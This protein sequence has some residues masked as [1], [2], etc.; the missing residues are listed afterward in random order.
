MKKTIKIEFKDQTTKTFEV[1][2]LATEATNIILRNHLECN[3]PLFIEVGHA[4]L[5][6]QLDASEIKSFYILFFNE[7]SRFSGASLT[8]SNAQGDFS[9]ITQSKKILFFPS[10]I[11]FELG[12]VSRIK[13]SV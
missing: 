10:G 13:P 1:L 8:D 4:S 11:D 5:N 3:Q 6:T 12:E 2:S 9:I 7:E